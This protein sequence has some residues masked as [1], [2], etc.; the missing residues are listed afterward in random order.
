MGEKV[1]E[2]EK[3]AEPEL[4]IEWNKLK[5]KSAKLKTTMKNSKISPKSQVQMSNEIQNPNFKYLTF[6][7][8]TFI[9]HLVFDI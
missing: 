5:T 2:E 1:I 7:H 3:E 9:C 6:S 4:E 8:L